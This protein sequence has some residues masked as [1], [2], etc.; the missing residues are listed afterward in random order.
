M[1]P[2]STQRFRRAT[3]LLAIA[4]ALFALALGVRGQLAAARHA[5]PPFSYSGVAGRA[6]IHG[7]H[8][9]GRSGRPRA[10]RSPARRR[11]RSRR[12]LDA[13]GTLAARAGA[14]EPL[15]RSQ[16]QRRAS[17]RWRLAPLA[18][19]VRPFP[20]EKLLR[21]RDPRGGRGVP[22]RS[23]SSSGRCAASGATRGR[24]SC[25]ARSWPPSSSSPGPTTRSSTLLVLGQHAADRRR[26]LL[27]LQRLPVRAAGLRAPTR[28]CARIPWAALLRGRAPRAA[29]AAPRAAAPASRRALALLPRHGP[30]HCVPRRSSATSAGATAA[31]RA[32]TAPT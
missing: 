23:G 7:A 4:W 27:P 6:I 31:I 26:G 32:S 1:N 8:A 17:S 9:A 5:S 13:R 20:V 16:A 11:R 3:A 21:V 28:A 18:P 14:P 24:C 12:R 2:R 22:R 29:R 19:G 30:V 25:S 10:G 15:P